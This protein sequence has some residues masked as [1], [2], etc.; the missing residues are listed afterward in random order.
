M[1]KGIGQY[2]TKNNKILE[3]HRSTLIEKKENGLTIVDPFVG[4]GDLIIYYLGLFSKEESKELLLKNKVKGFDIDLNNIKFIIKHL[5]EYYNINKELLTRNFRLNDSLENNLTNRDNDFILTNPPYLAKN[6]CKTK[7]IKLHKKYFKKNLYQDLYEVSINK[8]I[9]ND[10]IWI[11]PN[12]FISSK[13]MQKLREKILKKKSIENINI[14][15]EQLF[16]DT[17]ISVCSIEILKKKTKEEQKKLDIK[18]KEDKISI[19]ITRE[20]IICEE[21]YKLLEVKVQDFKLGVI[22]EEIPEGDT[23]ITMINEMGTISKKNTTD[24]YKNKITEN[25]LI[26]RSI[27]TGSYKNNLEIGLY[28]FKEIYKDKEVDFMISK[29]TTRSIIPIIF[30]E[31]IPPEEQIKIKNKFNEIL[32]AYRKKYMSIFLSDFKN[33][34]KGRIRKRLS[35]REASCLL[36]YVINENKK[37]EK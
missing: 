26:F 11:I 3:N 15:N 24:L 28:H 20:G 25:I 4:Q 21:W 29:K 16:I 36:Q 2:Y 6:V 13:N 17:K 18:I 27:D 19:D 5:S 31:T 14:Y 35:F 37:N 22:E 10:G 8:Y 34:T 7:F 32:S 23:S 33:T 1:Q 30:K 12:N 9:N